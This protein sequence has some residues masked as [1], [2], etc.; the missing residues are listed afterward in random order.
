MKFNKNRIAR[1]AGLLTEG[2]EQ[3]PSM[4]NNPNTIN[5][6]AGILKHVD[7]DALAAAL[8]EAGY[9]DREV[10]QLFDQLGVPVPGDWK[11]SVEKLEALYAKADAD[12]KARYGID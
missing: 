12:F 10:I 5:I 1:L 11:A 7:S 2:A 9:N 4:T 8:D 6:L 3:E